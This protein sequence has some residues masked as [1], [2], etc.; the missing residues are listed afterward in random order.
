MKHSSA[1][2]MQSQ[3]NSFGNSAVYQKPSYPWRIVLTVLFRTAFSS[4]IHV[5]IIEWYSLGPA[6]E[7]LHFLK[8][9]NPSLNLF[10]SKECHPV[11]S[12]GSNISARPGDSR[13]PLKLCRFFSM[14]ATA[15]PYLFKREPPFHPG[16]ELCHADMPCLALVRSQSTRGHPLLRFFIV[17]KTFQLLFFFF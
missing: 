12:S 11:L 6:F 16:C 9:F 3:P 7:H 14:N 10:K 17:W 2:R 15:L 5:I 8:N 13:S 1:S 4:I